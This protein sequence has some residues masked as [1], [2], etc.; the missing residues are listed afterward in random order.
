MNMRDPALKCTFNALM[1]PNRRIS[2]E[3]LNWFRFSFYTIHLKVVFDR[4]GTAFCVFIMC[5]TEHL[6]MLHS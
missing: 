1:P 5:E 4:V 6:S 3:C 2:P